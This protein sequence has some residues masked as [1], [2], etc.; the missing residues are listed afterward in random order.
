MLRRP[1]HVTRRRVAAHACPDCHRLWALRG[2]R[3]DSGAWLILCAFCGWSD[4]RPTGAT[5]GGDLPSARVPRRATPDETG[6]DRWSHGVLL[7]E[8]DDELLAVLEDYLVDGWARGA[9]GLVIAT[10]EHRRALHERLHAHGMA[11]TPGEGRLVELDAVATLEQFMRDG[12]PDAD[13]FDRTVGSLVRDHAADGGLRGFG[14][15]V[16]VLWAAGNAVGALELERLWSGLQEQVSFTLLCAYATEHVDPEDRD[17]I[18][19]AH[20]RQLA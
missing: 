19:H 15:M 7:Y 9:V 12:A 6:D 13:L 16:D 18:A 4:L 17:T 20:D 1:A 10:P 5:R 11:R 14:E 2:V 3:T 8:H